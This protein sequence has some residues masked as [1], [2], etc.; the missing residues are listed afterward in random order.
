MNQ[1]YRDVE[2]CVDAVI[3]QVGQRIVLGLPIG[4]GKPNHFVNALFARAVSDPSLI[5]KIFTGLSFV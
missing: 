3:S 4:I 1:T 2:N 5:L